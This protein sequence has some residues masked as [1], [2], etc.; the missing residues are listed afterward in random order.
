VERSLSETS[1]SAGRACDVRHVQ[2]LEV[3]GD[4]ADGYAGAENGPGA[5]FCVHVV[6][7]VRREGFPELGAF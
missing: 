4:E 6:A 5:F 7:H 3:G 2:V 1:R